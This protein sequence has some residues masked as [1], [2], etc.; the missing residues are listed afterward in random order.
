MGDLNEP[1]VH[2]MQLLRDAHW[3]KVHDFKRVIQVGTTY[4]LMRK[5]WQLSENQ[6]TTTGK[7]H[8]LE[9]VP[10]LSSS[11]QVTLTG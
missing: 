7:F 1:L 11:N 2:R 4:W 10:N 9:L 3:P 8:H 6:N 5:P